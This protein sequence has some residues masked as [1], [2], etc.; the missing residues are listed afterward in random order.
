ME[1]DGR[2]RRESETELVGW[3]SYLDDNE[4]V[5]EEARRP[6]L[7]RVDRE[8]ARDGS[9]WVEYA[10]PNACDHSRP[11]ATEGGSTV[12]RRPGA[13]RAAEVAALDDVAFAPERFPGAARELKGNI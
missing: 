5:G 11:L 9:P 7:E 3:A 6:A 4:L 10:T 1:D 2:R 12:G 8:S 13:V